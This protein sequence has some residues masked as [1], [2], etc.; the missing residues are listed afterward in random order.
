MAAFNKFNQFVEDRANKVHNL[1][2]DT[3]KFMLTNVAPV[4]ANSVKA[5]L[6]EIAAG[7]GY[8][9][10]GTAVAITSSTQTGGTYSL[11]PTADV[12]FTASGGSIG[13]FRYVVLY[14][15]TPTSPVDPLISWYDRGSSVTLLDTE[16]FTVDV[17]A[18]LLTDS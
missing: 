7:N 1:G 17:G 4:T 18:T 8:A 2:A 10:G 9:A 3:L 14:N 15:D 13:P 12:V 6:T 11:V 16:T 5:D